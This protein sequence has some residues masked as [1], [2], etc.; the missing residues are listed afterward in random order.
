[1]KKHKLGNSRHSYVNMT[2]PSL[3]CVTWS[4]KAKCCCLRKV[5]VGLLAT[6]R[7]WQL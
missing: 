2:V 4:H 6:Q 1:M 3:M 7:Q 5:P